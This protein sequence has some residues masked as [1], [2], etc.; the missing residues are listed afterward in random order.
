MARL[1]LLACLPWLFCAGCNGSI[2]DLGQD[3]ASTADVPD[4]R[5][6]PEADT[7]ACPPIG[8]TEYAPLRGVTCSGVCTDGIVAPRALSTADDVAAALAGQWTLC[9]GALGPNDTAG[10]E[11]DPGCV[12]YLLRSDGTGGLVRGTTAPYQGT[13]DVVTR[14]TSVLGIA[15]HL[16]T[17]TLEA[18]VLASGCLGRARLEP[19][20]SVDSGAIDLAAVA[21][22]GGIVAR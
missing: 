16:S 21:A 7:L 14:G 8:E 17:G 12:V 10:I 15:L 1:P 13:Y 19:M 4:E 5:S 9:G 6:A 18:T 11:L 20:G 22:D 2:L 3:D